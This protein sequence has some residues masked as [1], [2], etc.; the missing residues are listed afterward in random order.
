ML[1][2][3]RPFIEFSSNQT[4]IQG[5]VDLN[6]LV[7][8]SRQACE[9]AASNIS[10]IVR[11]KQSLMSDSDSYLPLCLPTF[12]V[13]SM[14]QSSLIHLA[15]AI[16]NRDSLR[17]L[18]L[19]Q[20]SISLLK[21]H[22][23]LSSGQ[24]A[25]NILIMLVAINGI[26]IDNL[27]KE[28]QKEEDATSLRED[29][30]PNSPPQQQ[31]ELLFSTP[32]PQQIALPRSD[33]NKNNT[34]IPSCEDNM[35]KSAWYQRMMNTSIVGGITPDL[36]G[37]DATSSSQQLEQLL[38]YHPP[39]GHHRSDSNATLYHPSEADIP[40]PPTY[41]NNNHYYDMNTIPPPASN[42]TKLYQFE[43]HNMHIANST[44]TLLSHGNFRNNV[45]T[46]P[47]HQPPFHTSTTTSSNYNHNASTY[48]VNYLPPSNLNWGE[49][50]VYLGQQTEPPAEERLG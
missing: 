41:Q 3:H 16:K 38:P 12:F 43:E 19:L 29:G 2:L 8:D 22:Q 50:G 7:S 4:T 13:Y 33:T 17:R 10:V 28:N 36:H 45:I 25:H 20:R 27:L 5:S 1:L 31:N 42:A 30:L 24:R 11:Q 46:A 9:N 49:W 37:R 15:I 32:Q 6:I 39:T 18:R 44:P 48:P 21:Q 35:P 26:N 40:P 23:A 34:M 47:I 14:F